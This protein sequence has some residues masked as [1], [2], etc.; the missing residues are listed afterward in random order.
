MA[1]HFSPE[2][3]VS[4]RRRM[5]NPFFARNYLRWRNVPFYGQ[6]LLTAVRYPA[7]LPRA[8]R[9]I[10]RTGRLEDGVETLFARYQY[11]KY[12]DGYRR[13]ELLR[14]SPP[15]ARPTSRPKAQAAPAKRQRVSLP[16]VQQSP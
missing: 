15:R 1:I 16:V 7:T 2:E 14:R 9:K 11:A 13:T 3:L 10:I 4:I 12:L 6:L 5:A 8:F